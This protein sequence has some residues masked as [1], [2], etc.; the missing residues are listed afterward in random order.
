[1][2]GSQNA[3]LVHIINDILPKRIGLCRLFRVSMNEVA[4]QE[5]ETRRQCDLLRIQLRNSRWP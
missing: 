2:L 3:S 5:L 4:Q 1:M